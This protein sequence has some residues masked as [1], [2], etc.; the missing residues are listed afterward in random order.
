MKLQMDCVQYFHNYFNLSPRVDFPTAESDGCLKKFGKQIAEVGEH[1]QNYLEDDPDQTYLRCHLMAEELGEFMIALAAGDE[2]KAADGLTDLLYV[3]IGT[4]LT[5]GWPLE[6]LFAEVH[7]SNMTKTKKTE[8]ASVE[9]EKRLRDKGAKFK[10]PE[11]QKVLDTHRGNPL[12]RPLPQMK[13]MHQAFMRKM[14]KD[15]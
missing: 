1:L 5:Y 11:I 9:D 12:T 6:E 2:V 14:A 15:D 4:A 3:L 8:N 13:I 10:P 7:A